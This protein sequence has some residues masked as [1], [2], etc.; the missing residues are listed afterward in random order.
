MLRLP[1]VLLKLYKL[2]VRYVVNNIAKLQYDITAII[3]KIDDLATTEHLDIHD[4][5][6]LQRYSDTLRNLTESL[7]NL[8]ERR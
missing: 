2:G 1:T 3:D 6:D 7:Y 5:A 4:M 8:R